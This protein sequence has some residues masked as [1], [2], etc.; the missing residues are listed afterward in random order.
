MELYEKAADEGSQMACFNLANYYLFG[1]GVEENTKEKNKKKV[2]ELWKRGGHIDP[3]HSTL[4]NCLSNIS[5]FSNS[6]QKELVCLFFLFLCHLFSSSFLGIFIDDKE[7]DLFQQTVE[8]LSM[9]DYVCFVSIKT[10][11]FFD[12]LNSALNKHKD[13]HAEAAAIY[14]AI[15]KKGSQL[16]LLNL[17]NCFMFGLGVRMDK[18]KGLDMFESCGSLVDDDLEWMRALSND[19]RLGKTSLSLGVSFFKKG[20]IIVCYQY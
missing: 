19:Q 6:S 7:N 18:K 14:T 12:E 8:T 11:P 13:S 1:V 17:G 15:S 20:F 9:H 4:F 16:A 10:I 2:I 5:L 3:S